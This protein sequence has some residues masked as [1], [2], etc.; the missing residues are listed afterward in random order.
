[1][2]KLKRSINLTKDTKTIKKNEDQIV[3]KN[4]SQIEI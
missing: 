4:K 1:M 2:V 3:Q